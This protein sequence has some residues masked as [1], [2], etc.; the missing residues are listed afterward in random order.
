[1][2]YRVLFPFVFGTFLLSACSPQMVAPLPTF[3]QAIIPEWI[4]ADFDEK[5]GQ[6]LIATSN[7]QDIVFNNRGE[8]IGWYIKPNAGTP[9]IKKNS[10]GQYDFSSLQ[11]GHGGIANMVGSRA[12]FT[13]EAEGIDPKEEVIVEGPFF[14]QNNENNTQTATF[15]YSQDGIIVQKD[16]IINQ[17]NFKIDLKTNITGVDEAKILFPG[18]GRNNNPRVQAV[19]VGNLQP[20][21]VT[22]N[23]T[24]FVKNAQYAALQEQPSQIAHALIIRPLDNSSI[25]VE[26]TGGTE[27]LLRVDIA[28]KS[29]LEIF[30]GKNE[31]IHLYQSGYSVL[32]ALFQPNF[33]GT[34]SLW[35][36]KV[37]EFLYRFIGDW[38]MV[39]VVLTILLRLVMWPMM[40]AQ[41]RSTAKMQL[42]Q[43]KLQEIQERYKD[44]KDLESQNAMRLETMEL[45][46]Q[47]N[48]NPAGCLSGFLP[49]P[50]LIAM[51]STIRNFEFDK[52]FLWLPDLAIPDPF[53]ILAVLYLV[54]NIGNLFV[55]T[56]KTPEMFKQQVFMYVFFVYFAFAFPSGVII[57][58]ILSTLIGV[59]QQMM[60]NQQVEKEMATSGITIETPKET[61]IIKAKKTKII[62]QKDV[63]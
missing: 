17:R 29:H 34:I 63:D 48:L 14:T 53:Y 35:L 58:S 5:P 56:R 50:I 1:M 49:F 10:N 55:M 30:G 51:W 22:G 27:G 41:G 59:I 12:A 4:Q 60:I 40:Q 7:L 45:Y 15:K 46:K 62:D 23:G 32:P 43:P 8:V 2:K 19:P 47:H 54:V 21:S 6:E 24:A 61:T 16:F 3:G 25:N 9:F 36:V 37:M 11:Q 18:L 31:L 33:F 57:Y 26:L 39:I 42:I 13:I 38:G 52:G 44:K 28:P 20:I